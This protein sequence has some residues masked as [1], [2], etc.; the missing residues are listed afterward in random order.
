MVYCFVIFTM[1]QDAGFQVAQVQHPACNFSIRTIQSVGLVGSVKL[2]VTAL[3][4]QRKYVLNF[5]MHRCEMPVY[6]L[7]K[8]FSRVE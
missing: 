8:V 5:R 2:Q 4:Q 1:H 6:I 7:F 3:L